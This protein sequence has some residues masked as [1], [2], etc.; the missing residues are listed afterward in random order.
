MK[1][2]LKKIF[3]IV[4][5]FWILVAIQIAVDE[6]D[7]ARDIWAFIGLIFLISWILKLLKKIFKIFF[8]DLDDYL[9]K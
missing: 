4:V 7:F 1:L 3:I 2:Y 9:M 5:A 8:K 6:I